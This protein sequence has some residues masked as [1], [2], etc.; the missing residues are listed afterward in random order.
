MTNEDMK[1]ELLDL[2]LLAIRV[3][4]KILNEIDRR[5]LTALTTNDLMDLFSKVGVEEE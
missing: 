1:E 4:K 3:S 5:D 2:G